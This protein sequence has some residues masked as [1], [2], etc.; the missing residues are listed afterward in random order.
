MSNLTEDFA[1]NV[2]QYVV[3]KT[4]LDMLNSRYVEI[5]ERLMLAIDEYGEVDGKGHKVID[6]TDGDLG[7]TQ[8]IKQRK[9]SKTLNMEIAE[10]LLKSKGIYEKC[11]T[12]VPTINEDAIMASYYEEKLTEEEIDS[13]F[14]VKVSYAFLAKN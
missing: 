14:P 6:L 2:K 12:L 4:Q 1:G 8:L 3:I 5:K 10:D 11:I 7:V 9:V 13:M